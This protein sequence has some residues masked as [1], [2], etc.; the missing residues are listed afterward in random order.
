MLTTTYSLITINAEQQNVRTILSRLRDYIESCVKGLQEPDLHRIEHALNK[1][2]QFDRYVHARKVEAV[3]IPSVRGMAHEIDT[4]L[5]ELESLSARAVELLRCARERLRAAAAQG[6]E[7][8]AD[9]F[10]AMRTY[11]DDLL[12]RLDREERELLP[13]LGRVVPGEHWF[14]IAAKFLSVDAAGKRAKVPPPRLPAP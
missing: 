8:A 10:H 7:K 14:S 11:C 12:R 9:A 2:A 5:A 1:L 6:A 3:L 13:L 4:L